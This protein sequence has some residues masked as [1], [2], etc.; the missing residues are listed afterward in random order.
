[1]PLQIGI[2]YSTSFWNPQ[3]PLLEDDRAGE[4]RGRRYRLES[5][6]YYIMDLQS[7]L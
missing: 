3:S 7:H 4:R 5:G 1:M 6:A 2:G